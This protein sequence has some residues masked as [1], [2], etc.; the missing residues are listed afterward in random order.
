MRSPG[1]HK[2][3][4]VPAGTAAF[5]I[6]SCCARIRHFRPIN[7]IDFHNIH[8][9]HLFGGRHLCMLCCSNIVLTFLTRILTK[10]PKSAH[11]W[12]SFEPL[13]KS[14]F[15]KGE[16]QNTLIQ[17]WFWADKTAWK[18]YEKTTKVIMDENTRN[19]FAS[20]RTWVRIP[21]SPPKKSSKLKGLLDFPFLSD[22]L[23][24]PIFALERR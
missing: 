6:T 23:N 20:N 15:F 19:Q 11:F 21:S 9:C 5:C 10:L 8:L 1:A 18:R 4:S 17:L 14:S 24:F 16:C 12:L 13:E 2:K 22:S 3:A 7:V